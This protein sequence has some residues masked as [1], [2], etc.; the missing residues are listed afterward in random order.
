MNRTSMELQFAFHGSA[1][2][3]CVL[4]ENNAVFGRLDGEDTQIEELVVQRAQRQT[5]RFDVWP[6][7]RVKLLVASFMQ[8]AAV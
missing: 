4:T 7:A 2:A 3:D 8:P 6:A 1:A 5:V